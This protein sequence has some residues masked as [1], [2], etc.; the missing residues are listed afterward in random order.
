MTAPSSLSGSSI[1]ASD[2]SPTIHN[3]Y[4]QSTDTWQY[5]IADPTSSHCIVL[6]PVRDRVADQAVLSTNAADAIIAVV[7]EHNYE[8]DYIL[9]THASG[10]S[11]LSAA[12]Y[13]RMQFS[14]SQGWPPQVCNEDTVSGLEKMWRRKYGANN[15]F[16]TTIRAGLNDGESITFGSLSLTCL[17]LPGFKTSHRRAYHIGG[18]IFGAHSI[19]TL[20]EEL[21][22]KAASAIPEAATDDAASHANEAWVSMQRILSL[23]S[24]TRVWREHGDGGASQHS[25]SFDLLSQC[26]AA[27]KHARCSESEFLSSRRESLSLSVGSA[28]GPRRRSGSLR[29]LLGH[30]AKV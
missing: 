1:T 21:S 30:R 9:E 12:W 4:A 28:K 26:A 16:S 20:E 22:T 8:V 7:N 29:G 6:D 11:C 10:S 3:I 18:D 17:Q 25:R 5:I 13:L 2:V 24:N 15:N 27:N 23:P 19:A 14:G